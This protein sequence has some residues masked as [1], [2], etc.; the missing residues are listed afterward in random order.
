MQ[1]EKVYG[2]VKMTATFV[3]CGAAGNLTAAVF[4]PRWIS[5]GPEPGLMGVVTVLGLE[6]VLDHRRLRRYWVDTAMLA[7]AV[8]GLAALG[9]FPGINLWALFGAT[10]T[11]CTAALIYSRRLFR[12]DDAVARRHRRHVAVIGFVIAILL[13]IA[14]VVGFWVGTNGETAWCRVCEEA[15]FPAHGWCDATDI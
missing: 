4:T 15:C 2:F 14:L 3:L 6:L 10:V 9:G 1:Q 13:S 7:L 11:G 12:V 8:A 5:T